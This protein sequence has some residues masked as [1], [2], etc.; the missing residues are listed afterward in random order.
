MLKFHLFKDDIRVIQSLSKSSLLSLYCV[1]HYR[2][3][4]SPT[5]EMS[6]PSREKVVKNSTLFRN[7][8]KFRIYK[9]L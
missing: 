4:L 3:F 2:V 6:N 5:L 9:W 1:T 8:T 7:M